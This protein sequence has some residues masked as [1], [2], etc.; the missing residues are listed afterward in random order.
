VRREDYT[1]PWLPEPIATPQQHWQTDNLVLAE[2]LSMAMLHLLERLSPNERAAFLLRDV[3]DIPY[4]RVAEILEETPAYCRKLVSRARGHLNRERPRFEAGAGRQKELE[5]AFGT[6]VEQGNLDQL[7]TLFHEDITLYC[8]GGGRAV[9]A[10][11]PI[12]GADRVSRF[13]TGIAGKLPPQISFHPTEIN[14]GP[15]C[16][17]RVGDTAYYVLA[18]ETQG[19]A[20]TGIRMM[21]NPEKLAAFTFAQ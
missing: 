8:D 3:F 11:R 10:L 14:G 9:A 4:E 18:L 20:I 7:L 5:K 21:R 13:F 15:G 16:V 12:Y 17:A 6:A 19:N 2:S 1:G